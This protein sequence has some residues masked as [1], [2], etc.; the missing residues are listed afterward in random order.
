VLLRISAPSNLLKYKVHLCHHFHEVYHRNYGVTSHQIPRDFKF[1]F[2][3][4]GV[5]DLYLFGLITVCL[6][7]FYIGDKIFTKMLVRSIMFL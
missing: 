5:L 3:S 6:L 7:S 4:L 2:Q 1:T